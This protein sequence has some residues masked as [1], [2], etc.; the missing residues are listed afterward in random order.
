M[1]YVRGVSVG[2]MVTIIVRLPRSLVEEIDRL[3]EDRGVDR[4]AVVRELLSVAVREARVRRALDLVREGRVSVWRAAEIA[5][6][7]Y[8]EMLELLRKHDVP[9]PLS[10]EEL[11]RELEEIKGDE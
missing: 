4:S 2:D 7:T 9:F 3:A 5:G 10:Q 6:V 11:L 1:T 8:R